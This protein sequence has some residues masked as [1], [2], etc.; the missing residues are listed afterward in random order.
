[1]LSLML[2]LTFLVILAIMNSILFSSYHGS[3]LAFH[4]AST[5]NVTIYTEENASDTS[6][7][8][9][10]SSD[11]NEDNELLPI[12]TA[13]E[14]YNHTN[15]ALQALTEGNTSEILNQLKITKEKLSLIIFGNESGQQRQ[16]PDATQTDAESSDTSNTNT[17]GN[18]EIDLSEDTAARENNAQDSEQRA[19]ESES[20]EK[21]EERREII[22]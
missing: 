22:P 1:M 9:Q 6:A 4:T 17:V 15:Q 3:A 2:R 10:E 5:A 19:I 12:E 14:I 16:E 20:G 11:S 18:V 21:S 13:T 8:Q 7:F